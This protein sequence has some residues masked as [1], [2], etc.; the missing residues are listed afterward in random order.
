MGSCTRSSKIWGKDVDV[1]VWEAAPVPD[2]TC[3]SGRDLY[4]STFGLNSDV[5]PSRRD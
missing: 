3:C 1:S 2:D 4:V 5:D